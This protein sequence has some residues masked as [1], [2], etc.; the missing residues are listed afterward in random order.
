MFDPYAL[1]MG[2]IE[3]FEDYTGGSLA[4]LAKFADLDPENPASMPPAKVLTGMA[5]LAI[6]RSDPAATIDTARAMSLAELMAAV[7][8]AEEPPEE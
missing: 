3:T 4:D 8:G 5:F 2:D 7:Q 1:T 6:R